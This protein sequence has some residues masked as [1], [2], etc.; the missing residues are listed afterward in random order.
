MITEQELR[1]RSWFIVSLICVPLAIIYRDWY[2]QV[3]S[4]W[5]LYSFEASLLAL[6]SIGA[7]VYWAVG[8]F[9]AKKLNALEV[10]KQMLKKQPDWRA[11]ISIIILAIISIHLILGTQSRREY[12]LWQGIRY[13]NAVLVASLLDKGVDPNIKNEEG[14]TPLGVAVSER[15]IETMNVLIEH[16]ANIN[17]WPE[18][19]YNILQ[20]PLETG[21][22]IITT[23]L[24]KAGAKTDFGKNRHLTILYNQ[25]LERQLRYKDL[26]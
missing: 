25:Y 20:D 2:W 15:A 19:G 16:K 24:V 1:S 18:D 3:N 13:N 4:I 7:V 23:A 8:W 11:I 10:Y 17:V 22:D 26:E 9:W 6:S 5:S 14:I 21:M 12:F